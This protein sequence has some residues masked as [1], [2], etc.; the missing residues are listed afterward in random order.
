MSAFLNEAPSSPRIAQ[1]PFQQLRNIVSKNKIRYQQDGFDL[2]LSFITDRVIAMGYPSSSIESTYRNPMS[3][4]QRFLNSKYENHYKVYNL[5]QEKSYDESSFANVGHYP[6]RDHNACPLE[7]LKS[8][9][10][11][12]ATFYDADEKNVI[13]IHCKAGIGRTKLIICAFLLSKGI[14]N[15][16][17]DAIDIFHIKRF[18]DE[19]HTSIP[20]Q[21][22]YLQYFYEDMQTPKIETPLY[23]IRSITMSSIPNFD[24]A[25]GCNPYL[26]INHHAYIGDNACED[27]TIIDK[28]NYN[29]FPFYSSKSYHVTIDLSNKNMILYGD[30]KVCLVDHDDMSADDRMCHFWINTKFI[31]DEQIILTKDEL[32]EAH[33]D[34]AGKNFPKDFVITINLEKKTDDGEK[35]FNKLIGSSVTR[36]RINVTV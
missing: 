11:D 13:A 32:D 21:M 24:F 22:R 33:K 5:C 25:G 35:M 14:C 12:M 18:A 8:C 34:E 30:N 31:K 3:E 36:K 4:V 17:E 6:F 2:D 26:T 27:V 16:I 28:K 15:S 29:E 7:L 20:S 9:I 10:Q 1:N 19:S 23:L